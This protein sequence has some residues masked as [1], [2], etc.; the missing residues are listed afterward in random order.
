MRALIQ[1]VTSASVVVENKAVG[2]IDIG[3]LLFV[4]IEE[5]DTLEDVQYLVSKISQLRIFPDSEG[6]MNLSVSDVN[7]SM[8]A[9]SQFTLHAMTKKGNRPSFIKA[10]KAIISEPLFN[11]FVS[12]LKKTSGLNVQ[13]GIFG[14]DMKVHLV[15]DGPVTIWIDSKNKE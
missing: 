14:A 2:A 8:L 5:A 15:N 4:G 12:E 6:K 9:V 10:A 13:T 11:T 7:G 1:R 3:L